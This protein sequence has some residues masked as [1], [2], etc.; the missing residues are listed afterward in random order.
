MPRRIAIGKNWDV[1]RFGSCSCA[2]EFGHMQS[3]SQLRLVP[4]DR[5]FAAHANLEAFENASIN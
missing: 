4:R 3:F 5:S 1:G 2:A